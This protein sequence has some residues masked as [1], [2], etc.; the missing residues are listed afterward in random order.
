MKLQQVING[1]NVDEMN[2]LVDRVT[3]DPELGKF[4]L[5]VKN[6]WVGGTR[7]RTTIDDFYGMGRQRPHQDIFEL[8]ADE[9]RELLG[10]DKGPNATEALLYA[11]AS[12]LNTT[13]ICQAV[14]EGLEIEQLE[15]DIEGNIDL[16]GFLGIEEE[17]RR[18]YTDIH[19]T[20][21]A[22]ADLPRE[23]LEGLCRLAQKYSPV[24]DIV[25][26]EVPVTVELE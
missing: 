18:G 8:Q 12:C 6:E 25:T 20:V 5:R 16:R 19:V 1:I 2:D 10:T 15:L 9:P 21:R 24:F 4:K 22:K 11:L 7:C 3:S 14:A 23:K 17:V 26:H 13:F